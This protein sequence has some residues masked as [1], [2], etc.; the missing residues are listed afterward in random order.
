MVLEYL[1][2]SKSEDELRV[3]C[4]CTALA[5]RA[6]SAVEAARLLGFNGTRKHNLDIDVL[7]VQLKKGLYPIAFIAARLRSD[8]RPGEHAVVVIEVDKDEVSLLDPVRGE[9]TLSREEFQSEWDYMRRLAILI[10][11]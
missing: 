7:E 6:G 11:K 2:V 4:D 9:I 10:E 5:T 3:L 1:G 8:S